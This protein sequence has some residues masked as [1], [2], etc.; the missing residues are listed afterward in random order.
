MRKRTLIVIAL[1]GLFAVVMAGCLPGDGAA[2][3]AKPA[4]F[5]SGIWHGWVAPISLIGKIF[6]KNLRIY[7]PINK[8]FWYDLAFYM[9]IV[10][11]F[12]GVSL[13]RK[14]RSNR[15]D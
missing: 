8:G 11:G 12:G 4:G 2:T 3:P 9:A 7:E 13:V 10:G 6:N 5:W 15:G 14:S 1:V